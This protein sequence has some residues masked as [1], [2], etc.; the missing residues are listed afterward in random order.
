MLDFKDGFKRNEMSTMDLSR[1]ERRAEPRF[2][3]RGTASLAVL[4]GDDPAWTQVS[5]I[6]VSRSGVQLE[7]NLPL[8]VGVHVR[9]RMS[10]DVIVIGQ[11]KNLRAVGVGCYR[12]GVGVIALNPGLDIQALN[13]A[14]LSTESEPVLPVQPACSEEVCVENE[15]CTPKK[16]LLSLMTIVRL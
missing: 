16:W 15:D 1:D 8:E 10:Q 5:V 14:L 2:C 3:S 4:N 6:E 11:V 9:I 7:Y 13:A 12:L